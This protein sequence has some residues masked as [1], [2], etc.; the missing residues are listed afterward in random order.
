[1]IFKFFDIPS[2][3]ENCLRM[4]CTKEGG[5]RTAE[6]ECSAKLRTPLK[7]CKRFIQKAGIPGRIHVGGE[8]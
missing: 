8:K 3:C 2:I 4:A 1:M 7:K 6:F 5:K